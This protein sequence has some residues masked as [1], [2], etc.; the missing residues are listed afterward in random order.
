MYLIVEYDP[1]SLSWVEFTTAETLLEARQKAAGIAEIN[2]SKAYA[3]YRNTENWHELRPRWIYNRNILAQYGTNRAAG[4]I[5]TIDSSF[6]P[7]Y[8]Q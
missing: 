4:L 8:R 7:E 1:D 6:S 2:T 3:V 5:N